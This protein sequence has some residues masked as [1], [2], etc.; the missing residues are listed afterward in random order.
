MFGLMREFWAFIWQ[1]KKYWL[2]PIVLALF[3]VGVLAVI[4]ESSM[5]SSFI[6]PFF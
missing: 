4:S 5:L 1:Q 2:L 6:Y 3:L